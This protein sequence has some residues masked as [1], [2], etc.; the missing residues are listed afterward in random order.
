[1]AQVRCVVD[2][3]LCKTRLLGS[4]ELR[5]TWYRWIW[6]DQSTFEV[7]PY[8]GIS[9][10]CA[11][12][13]LGTIACM[14]PFLTP[15]QKSRKLTGCGQMI[16]RHT[17]ANFATTSLGCRLRQGIGATTT[18][19]AI[20]WVATTLKIATA[21]FPVIACHERDDIRFRK[22]TI[23]FKN[24]R[25]AKVWAAGDVRLRRRA[26]LCQAY[27]LALHDCF[28]CHGWDYNDS[29]ER[30]LINGA[31][32]ALQMRNWGCPTYTGV[33]FSFITGSRADKMKSRWPLSLRKCSKVSTDSLLTE[34]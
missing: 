15:C 31:N 10:S 6:T 3:A 18:A 29:G 5:W 14:M 21:G 27:H 2:V 13:R 25:R 24:R 11:H 16:Q 19:T 34:A 30:T 8:R 22:M 17:W 28:Q 20:N 4:F 26:C 9:T 7:W 33:L 32:M 1:M 23:C 12:F